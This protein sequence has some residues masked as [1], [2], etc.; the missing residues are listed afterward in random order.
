MTVHD[1]QIYRGEEIKKEFFE[2]ESVSIHTTSFHSEWPLHLKPV[3]GVDPP[4]MMTVN[5]G[6]GDDGKHDACW[7]HEHADM[8]MPI[9]HAEREQHG[10]TPLRVLSLFKDKGPYHYGNRFNIWKLSEAVDKWRPPSTAILPQA[11]PLD[12]DV[13]FDAPNHGKCNLDALHAT[14]KWTLDDHVMRRH[15]TMLDEM[16]ETL[17]DAAS[18]IKAPAVVTA[19]ATSVDAATVLLLLLQ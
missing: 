3:V 11:P 6:L 8:I 1:L 13:S 16:E 19:V 7:W 17:Q 5:I 12:I 14:L 4:Q 18:C 9:L 15:Q 10:L 2:H